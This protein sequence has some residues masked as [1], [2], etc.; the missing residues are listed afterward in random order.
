[1]ATIDF[2]ALATANANVITS[3]YLIWTANATTGGFTGYSPDGVHGTVTGI[4]GTA[5]QYIAPL[6]SFIVE[7][8]STFVDNDGDGNDATA[9]LNLNFANNIQATG[10]GALRSSYNPAN[11]L[12]IT[13]SNA[14]A[15]VL[16]FIANRE[17]GQSVFGN[18]DAR[19]LFTTISAVPDIYTLKPSS[20]GSVAVGANII[21]TDDITIPLGIVTSHKGKISFTFKGMDNYDAE[22]TLID[23]GE[24]IPLTGLE[25][26]TYDFTLE[27]TGVPVENRFAIRLAPTSPTGLNKV[28]DTQATIYSKNH[29]L[30]AVSGA[31]D[32]IRQIQIFNVHGQLIYN[33]DRLNTSYYTIDRRINSSEIYVV[34]LITERCV[35]NVK[36]VGN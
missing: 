3:N 26:H 29:T 31:S 11:K 32:K 18:R 30:F 4:T 34:K 5:D 24:E 36:V 35:K 14:A 8:S 13:A 28:G 9:N 20:D 10:L 7:K 1:M 25:S 33:N 21:G 15:S 17:G 23:N 6:Q 22:I 16:T 27:T 19:K 12:E 2:D